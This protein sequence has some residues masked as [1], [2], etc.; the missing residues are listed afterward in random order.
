M[1]EIKNLQ[2]NYLITYVNKA[3]NSFAII[4]KKYYFENLTHTINSSTNYDSYKIK[5][6][7]IINIL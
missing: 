6:R 7:E 5:E 3:D 1:E 2:K 4:H